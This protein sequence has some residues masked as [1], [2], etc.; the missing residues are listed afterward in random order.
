MR[1]LPEGCERRAGRSSFTV[2]AT[3]TPA[4]PL[5]GARRRRRR[6][7]ADERR[8]KLVPP[9]PR[10]RLLLQKDRASRC[11]VAT[12]EARLTAAR[13]AYILRPPTALS[14]DEPTLPH[15]SVHRH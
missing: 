10:L 8:H 3:A 11:S 15:T 13:A 12:C 1:V 6:R 2:D 14:A 5:A 9:E 7:A 4:A